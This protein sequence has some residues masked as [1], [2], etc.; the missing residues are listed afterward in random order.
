MS[1]CIFCG[2]ASGQY[3]TEFVAESEYA[4][5][6]K[7]IQPSQ[8]VHVLVVP[9]S[10]F[11]DVA[12]LAAKDETVL[13]DLIKLGTRVASEQTNGDF[14]LQFNTGEGAGQTVFHAHGH[15]T[16]RTPKA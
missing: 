6:F 3:G 14:R 12:E 15:I 1:E 16:S 11:T 9:R 4:I 13:L 5:A 7:D 2:I 10:H 8:P